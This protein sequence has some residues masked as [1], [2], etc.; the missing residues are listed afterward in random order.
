MTN[1]E[2]P[3]TVTLEAAAI[4][5]SPDTPP[6]ATVVITCYN[7]G[8]FLPDA[9]ESALAQTYRPVETIVVDDGSTDDTAAVCR[10]YP[11]VRYIPQKNAGLSAARN[12][13][14][15]AARGDLVAFLDADDLLAPEAIAIG[16]K[17]LADHPDWAFVYGG[18]IGVD[19]ERRRI[20]ELVPTPGAKDYESL[21]R[22]NGIGMHATVLY[23]RTVL[24]DV[25]GFDPSLRASEDYDIY[26]RIAREYP[27]GSH[28]GIVAEYRR[29]E[30][31]MSEDAER[32]LRSSLG[33]L[34]AQRPASRA[35]RTAHGVGIA[36]YQQGYGVPLVKRAVRGLHSGRKGAL[37]ELGL[38]LRMAPRAFPHAAADAGKS[39]GRS[40]EGRMP[41]GVRRRLRRALAKAPLVPRPGE[42]DWGDL[43]RTTPVDPDFGY[44]RGTPVDRLYIERFLARRRGDIAGR[45]LEIGD[46]L[47]TM[48]FGGEKVTR[49]DV[50]HVSPDAPQATICG[51]LANAPQIPDATFDCIIVTQTLQFIFDVP[52]AV[53][54]LR[55]ILK[56]G[57]VLLLTVPGF[58][59]IDRGEWNH[60]WYW[61]GITT[62]AVRRLLSEGWSDVAI[63]NH[64]NVMAAVA[65]LHGIAAEELAEDELAATDPSYQ[66]IV[67]ARAVKAGTSA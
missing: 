2:T 48:R 10:R 8:H 67:A 39:L 56:P 31:N 41:T 22:R 23:Q 25:G 66:V 36:F 27:I 65:F 42:V 54:T 7:H 9:I 63:E 40:L 52:A 34:R 30:A 5:G 43:K 20:W 44:G 37:R 38:A 55:R 1:D 35:E 21:L 57:G 64:G 60:T 59:Q 18:H 46:N 26:L 13:G 12:T 49:S 61:G 53:A 29:H 50:L 14:L 3:A 6:A 28:D 24:E 51:D 11:A 15:R 33:V 32:M 17:A 47:Y 16:A 62:V 19:A 4:A 45:V 58:S